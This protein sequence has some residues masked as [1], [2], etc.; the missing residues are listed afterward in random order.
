[1]IEL[2]ESIL[3]GEKLECWLQYGEYGEPTPFRVQIV[4]DY[5][6]ELAI[7]N[8]SISG[9]F[10]EKQKWCSVS[11]KQKDL[12]YT[13]EEAWYVYNKKRLGEVKDYES[14]FQ[15]EVEELKEKYTRLRDEQSSLL[16]DI[17]EYEKHNVVQKLENGAE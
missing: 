1:M 6:K 4:G 7:N 10:L 3:N 11:R 12:Y 15:R 14:M 8:S 5:E 17:Q 13:K 2:T 16:R 9:C